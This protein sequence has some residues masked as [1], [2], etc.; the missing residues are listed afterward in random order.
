MRFFRILK[1]RESNIVSRKIGNVAEDLATQ[2]LVNKHF[3]ILH[4]NFRSQVGEIDIICVKDNVISF[5]EVKSLSL[6]KRNFIYEPKEQITK[7]KQFRI[8]RTANYFI[9]I[10]NLHDVNFRFDL[11]EIKF[12]ASNK[13]SYNYIEN[14]F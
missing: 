12:W 9:S 13:Y 14:I 10:N 11:M 8:K 1:T 6:F 7:T 3:K 5:V 2:L 4:R